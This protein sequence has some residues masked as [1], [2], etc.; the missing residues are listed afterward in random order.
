MG[1]EYR[2]ETVASGEVDWMW[3]NEKVFKGTLK[4]VKGEFTNIVPF[5]A[6]GQVAGQMNGEVVKGTGLSIKGE[7]NQ[8]SFKDKNDNWQKDCSV[9]VSQFKITQAST[10][11]QEPAATTAPPAGDFDDGIPF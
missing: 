10:L 5:V 9:V 4:I 3:C 11:E 2:N 6:F 8:K 1:I 7:V